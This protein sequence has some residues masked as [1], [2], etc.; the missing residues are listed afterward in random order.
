MNRS[1]LGT[2]Q[3]V[4]AGLL[5]YDGL[6]FPNPCKVRVANHPAAADAIVLMLHILKRTSY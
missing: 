4:N 2:W 1:P 6:P 3:A 5:V